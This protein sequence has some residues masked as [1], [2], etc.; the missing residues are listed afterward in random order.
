MAFCLD[1][2]TPLSR[3]ADPQATLRYPPR[4]LRGTLPYPTSDITRNLPDESAK[5]ITASTKVNPLLITTVIAS[6][7]LMIV[8]GIA[9]GLFLKDR[10]RNVIANQPTPGPSVFSSPT[11]TAPPSSSL[12]SQ[13]VG[14]WKW[15]SYE[16]VY[17]SDGTGIEWDNGKK[18]FDFTYSLDGDVLSR[19]VSGTSQC[20]SGSGKW[21]MR[22]SGDDLTQTYIDNG[23]VSNWKKL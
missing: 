10:D 9:V 13:L 3:A 6:A 16:N 11:S 19:T 8:G 7:L 4:E 5:R 22:I 17:F 12:A 21:R 23:F 18:C 20:G 1:D 14:K 2:G 15:G